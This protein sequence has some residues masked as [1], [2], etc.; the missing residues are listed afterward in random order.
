MCPGIQRQWL[1]MP[2]LLPGTINISTCSHVLVRSS[3]S[4]DPKRQGK[5]SDSCTRL[6]NPILVLAVTTDDQPGPAVFL[7]VTKKFDIVTQTLCE[8]PAMQ[9]SPVNN[10]QG[11][12]TTVKKNLDYLQIANIII[13][14]NN[15][16]LIL[17]I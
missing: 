16:H 10:N 7:T 11:N 9:K 4:K 3:I 13:I 5:C 17:K 8:P 12:N 1:S 14:L 15:G 6:V 2:S